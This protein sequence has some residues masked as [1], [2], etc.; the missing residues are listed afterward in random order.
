MYNTFAPIFYPA[1][2]YSKAFLPLSPPSREISGLVRATTKPVD[3]QKNSLTGLQQQKKAKITETK[4][5]F[6][7][8][9]DGGI[10][11]M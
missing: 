4:A 2:C 6:I 3:F 8:L 1:P 5:I 7:V 11:L 10:N 9:V